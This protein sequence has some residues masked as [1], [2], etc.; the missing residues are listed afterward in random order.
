MSPITGPD[1]VVYY[2]KKENEEVKD[3]E[4]KDEEAK[5]E[6]ATE[7]APADAPAEDAPA[8]DAPTEDAPVEDAPEPAEEKLDDK[9][10][11]AAEAIMA[12]LDPEVI[13]EK[14]LA[15][16][17]KDSVTAPKKATS[18][19]DFEQ[20]MKKDVSEMTAKEKIVG[21]FQA[22]IWNDV[23]VLKALSEGTASEGGYLFPD[24]FRKKII[25]DLEEVP[26][27]RSRV[28]VIPMKRDVMKI[29]GLVDGPRVYWTDERAAKSTTTATFTEHTLTAYKMA[30]INA[31]IKSRIVLKDTIKKTVNCWELLQSRTISSQAFV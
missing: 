18:L 6:E 13:K 4:V 7:D 16:L 29:P 25:R 1:G 3:E 14:V 12:K 28:T 22:M 23:E 26:H 21:F 5:D 19:I 31:I 27:M 2:S 20:L 15:A 11:K 24:E 30:A 9:V 10:D 8:E 17:K